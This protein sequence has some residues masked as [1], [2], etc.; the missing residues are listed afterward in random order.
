MAI[1]FSIEPIDLLVMAKVVIART[2]G[3]FYTAQ[4]CPFCKGGKQCNSFTFIVHK[5]DGNYRCSRQKC[6]VT[7]NFWRLLEGLGLNPRDYV[8][9]Y[10]K[11]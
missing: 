4:Y 11:F 5:T 9:Q 10:T 7:G 2:S 6:G 8:E 3:K 1:K